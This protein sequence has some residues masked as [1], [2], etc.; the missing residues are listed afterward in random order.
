MDW[1]D[2]KFINRSEYDQNNLIWFQN[3]WL[4]NNDYNHL[5][6]KQ[7]IEHNN[8]KKKELIDTYKSYIEEY[9]FDEVYQYKSNMVI[10]TLFNVV[11]YI[12]L[13]FDKNKKSNNNDSN[14]QVNACLV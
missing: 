1:T 13:K 3:M 11:C 2:T 7:T 5:V 9:G 8:L 12:K 14:N 10:E 4:S 6:S